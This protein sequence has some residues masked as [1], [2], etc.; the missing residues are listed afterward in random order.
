MLVGE[1]SRS[2]C[3][4]FIGRGIGSFCIRRDCA[5]QS[6]TVRKRV[7]RTDGSY[8]CIARVGDTTIYSQEPLSLREAQV[9][10]V[11]QAE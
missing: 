8:F 5:D 2:L 11:T 9:P 10:K 3:F 1:S 7:D 6:H 4:G